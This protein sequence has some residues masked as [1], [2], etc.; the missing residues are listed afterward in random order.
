VEA[1]AGA[2]DVAEGLADRRRDAVAEEL[3]GRLG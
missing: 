2:D 1:G 3:V